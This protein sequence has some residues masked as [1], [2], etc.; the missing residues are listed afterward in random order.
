MRVEISTYYSTPDDM[1]N[2]DLKAIVYHNTD[3]GLYEVDYMKDNRLIKTES[4]QNYNL[5][6]HEDAAENYVLGVKKL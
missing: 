4:Y 6:Y 5:Y 2:D 1:V 3:T